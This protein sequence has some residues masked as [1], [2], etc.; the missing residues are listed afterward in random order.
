MC[1][2]GCV[3]VDITEVAG[4]TLSRV[5]PAMVLMC[6]IEMSAGGRCIR[7][8]AIALLM[9]V[10]SVLTRGEVFYLCGHL[11]F[12][13]H[14]AERNRADDAAS[15]LRLQSRERFGDILRVRESGQCAEHG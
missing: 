8:R 4:V 2:A 11:H 1:F 6:R 12:I 7:R 13:A 15:G 3:R 14:F 5:R 9:N 10:E